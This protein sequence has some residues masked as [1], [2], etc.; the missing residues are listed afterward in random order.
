MT[1]PAHSPH[2]RQPFKDHNFP[3]SGLNGMIPQHYD[4][5]WQGYTDLSQDQISAF[6]SFPAWQAKINKQNQG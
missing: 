2:P 1:N 4:P 5:K 3:I 6:M